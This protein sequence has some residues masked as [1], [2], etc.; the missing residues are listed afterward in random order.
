MCLDLDR[1]E[2]INDSFGHHVGE[3]VLSA[4]GQTMQRECPDTAHDTA[5]AGRLGGEELA[6]LLFDAEISSAIDFA[7]HMRKTIK[8]RTLPDSPDIIFTVGFGVAKW[9]PDMTA[10]TWM[11]AAD[12]VRYHAKEDGRNCL[13]REGMT[14]YDD[15]RNSAQG[16]RAFADR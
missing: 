8:G 11:A 13:V 9:R 14:E 3:A 2:A 7:E 10:K 12:P 15:H 4:E 6:V 1:V 5:L 16:W